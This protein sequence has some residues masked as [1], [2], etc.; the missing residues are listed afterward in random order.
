MTNVDLERLLD[1]PI[2]ASDF[3]Y[4]IGDVENFLEFSE[5]NME[6][7]YRHELQAIE[8]RAE[9]EELPEGY[10]EHLETNAEHRFR[11][12]LPLRVRYGAVIAL[13]PSVEWSIK[14]L[15]KALKEPISTKPKDRNEIVTALLELDKRTGVRKSKTVRDYEALVQVR[16]C[17]AHS[18]GIEEH[19]RHRRKLANAVARLS[20]FS[21]GGWH[22]FGKHVCIER[23]ALIPYVREMGELVVNLHRH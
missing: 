16:N 22:F 18:A 1:E 11:V 17:I 2:Y 14:F 19:Y 10:K 21:H 23:G 4:M 6:Q 15:A 3:Q 12:T 8:R 5:C 13:T 9:R 20:G 7:Q